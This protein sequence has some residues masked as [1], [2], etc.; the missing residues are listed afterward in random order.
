VSIHCPCPLSHVANRCRLG[1]F[2]EYARRQYVAKLPKRNPFGVEDEP[3]KFDDFD[4]F[5]KIR[6]LHQLS[7]WTLN[8][9]NPIRERLDERES[10]QINWVSSPPSFTYP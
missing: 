9:P 4:V 8:N 5:T 3:N 2:D 1:I 7:V 10:E 6:V